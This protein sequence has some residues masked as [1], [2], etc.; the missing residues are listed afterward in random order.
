[1]SR[2]AHHVEDRDAT[3]RHHDRL[4]RQGEGWVFAEREIRMAGA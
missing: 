4:R 1:M 3:R 2:H